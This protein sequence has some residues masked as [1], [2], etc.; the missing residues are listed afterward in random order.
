[1]ARKYGKSDQRATGGVRVTGATAPTTQPLRLRPEPYFLL[2]HSGKSWEL[3]ELPRKLVT[4]R[5][6]KADESD[7]VDVWL[8]RL[9]RLRVAP[10]VNGV[11]QGRAGTAPNATVALAGFQSR[12]WTIIPEDWDGGYVDR[13]ETQRGPVH[14]LR[15]DYPVQVGDRTVIRTKVDELNAWRLKLIAD[16]VISPPAP[17]IL[18][19]II[20]LQANRARRDERD[21]HVPTVAAKV[22]R[23]RA[24]LERMKAAAA[25]QAA[26]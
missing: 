7:T 5:K 6:P 12:G 21:V 16:G 8:P 3:Q 9:K 26:A 15:F 22:E 19:E 23:E 25:D 10:G 11:K 24:K 4:G 18:E 13:Y 17:E 14:M 20:D 1:M 2:M